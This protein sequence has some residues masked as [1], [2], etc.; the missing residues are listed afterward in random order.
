MSSKLQRRDYLN[1][2]LV[3]NQNN[4]RINSEH[5]TVFKSLG[6]GA[7]DLQKQWGETNKQGSN[8]FFGI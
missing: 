7:L 5:L 2:E 4:E 6:S 8:F 1:A 3:V